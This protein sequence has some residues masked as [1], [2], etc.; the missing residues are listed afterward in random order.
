[1]RCCT[2]R[3]QTWRTY[4]NGVV[5]YGF[6]P[7][8]EQSWMVNAE[9]KVDKLWWKKQRVSYILAWKNEWTIEC[10]LR[11]LNEGILILSNSI[12]KQIQRESSPT[13]NDSKSNPIDNNSN[14]NLNQSLPVGQ[15]NESELTSDIE[16]TPQ[17]T[18]RNNKTYNQPLS[19][20]S[21][22]TSTELIMSS[23]VR[24]NVQC[25]K[26]KYN[27]CTETVPGWSQ[28]SHLRC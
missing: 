5:L 15:K 17:E 12:H 26:Q 8:E 28:W 6:A 24:W 16:N 13:N 21:N 18:K 25:T 23:V 2:T 1:M 3:N 10:S 20:S 9:W 22:I 11:F 14:N 19:Q 7:Q 4:M 27:Q